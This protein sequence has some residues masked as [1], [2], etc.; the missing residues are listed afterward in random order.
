MFQYWLLTGLAIV[1]F[2]NAI[3][4]IFMG[5][6]ADRGSAEGKFKTYEFDRN[7]FGFSC[8]VGLLLVLGF[9][10]LHISNPHFF[11]IAV[12]KFPQLKYLYTVA[13]MKNGLYYLLGGGFVAGSLL[14]FIIRKTM[15]FF[16]TFTQGDELDLHKKAI[17]AHDAKVK[18]ERE[19]WLREGDRKSSQ[20]DDGTPL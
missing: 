19:E 10:C 1:F 20:F 14:A 18:S 13:K 7:P 3:W 11:P 8:S 6:F 12:K 16:A 5:S 9:A 15:T 4:L 2:I 17:K